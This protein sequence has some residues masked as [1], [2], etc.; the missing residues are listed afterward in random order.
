MLTVS[1]SLAPRRLARPYHASSGGG[2]CVTFMLSAIT[3]ACPSCPA[4][5]ASR[6]SGQTGTPAAAASRADRSAGHTLPGQ[7]AVNRTVNRQE[8]NRPGFGRGHRSRILHELVPLLFLHHVLAV[9]MVL[10]LLLLFLLGLPWWSGDRGRV[11]EGVGLDEEAPDR[12]GNV[13]V[14]G[15]W[16]RVP[17]V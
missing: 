5:P 7:T 11:V 2:G 8:A 1:N 10:V 17:W 13:D 3:D 16:R 15:D 9:L 6:R 4:D 12:E 14:A